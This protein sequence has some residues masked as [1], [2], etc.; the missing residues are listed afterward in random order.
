M[1]A[2]SSALYFRFTRKVTN[3]TGYKRNDNNQPQRDQ[4]ERIAETHGATL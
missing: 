2:S 4:E 1:T 3:S